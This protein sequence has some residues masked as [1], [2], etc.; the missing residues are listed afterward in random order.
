MKKGKTEQNTLLTAKT[1]EEFT[2][3]SYKVDQRSGD[4]TNNIEDA[5]NN[6]IDA[7]R[8]GLERCMKNKE[9]N[10]HHDIPY[11]L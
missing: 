6:C 3:Y 8:Y 10:D 11:S 4:I 1:I 9:I 7:I 5:Y 2:L